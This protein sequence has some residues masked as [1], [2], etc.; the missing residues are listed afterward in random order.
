MLLGTLQ[1]FYFLKIKIRCQGYKTFPGH[2]L[3]QLSMKFV[4]LINV[5]MP[6]IVGILTF[7]SSINTTYEG[8]KAN[9]IYFVACQEWKTHKDDVPVRVLVGGFQSITLEGMHPFHSKFQ[10][11]GT[12]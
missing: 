5:K 3:T 10:K 9:N 1:R 7:I 2:C 6:I 4:L 12:F 11:G 8:F